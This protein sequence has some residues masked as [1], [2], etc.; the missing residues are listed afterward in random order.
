MIDSFPCYRDIAV[1]DGQTCL[2]ASCGHSSFNSFAD[3][4]LK[5]A[6]ILVAEIWG[7]FEGRGAGQFDDID[8]MI[9]S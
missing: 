9:A 7:C 3:Y 5:R 6:Q 4:F 2:L 8:G 1:V